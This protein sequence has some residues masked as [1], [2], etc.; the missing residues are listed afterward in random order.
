M[1]QLDA[2]MGGNVHGGTILKLIDNTA[3]VVAARHSGGRVITASIDRVV[4]HAPV[5]VSDLLRVNASLN[6]TGRTSME[7]GVRVEA[8]EVFSGRVRHT[9]SAYLVI[10]AVDGAE[11]TG[12]GACWAGA[13]AALWADGA[14]YGD[15]AETGEGADC[16][17]TALRADCA[18]TADWAETVDWA[19][20]ADWADAAEIVSPGV[21]AEKAALAALTAVSATESVDPGPSR[22][23][24]L[25]LRSSVPSAKA[26]PIPPVATTAAML[27]VTIQ[28]R[29]FMGSSLVVVPHLVCDLVT[30]LRGPHEVSGRGR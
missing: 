29:L 27:P 5:H 4:F 22:S 15:W 30:T 14:E 7:V 1:T 6:W 2:N 28:L 3:A 9:G 16:A 8:E 12:A 20:T 25:R 18:E 19:E 11:Y 17:E 24:V 21:R 10:V 26:A 23:T 13:R